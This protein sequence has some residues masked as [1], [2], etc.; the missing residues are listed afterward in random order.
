M[1]HLLQASLLWLGTAATPMP[2][3]S[4]RR[5]SLAPTPELTA[6]CLLTGL[7]ASSAVAYYTA[8]SHVVI[9]VAGGV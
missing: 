2:S 4:G 5:V 7:T 1:R 3:A 8:T 9:G 6:T